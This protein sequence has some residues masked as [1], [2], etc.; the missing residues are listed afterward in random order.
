M[1]LHARATYDVNVMIPL[2]VFMIS[3]PL[4]SCLAAAALATMDL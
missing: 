3:D 4:D 1:P 2:D